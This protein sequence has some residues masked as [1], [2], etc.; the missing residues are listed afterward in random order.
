MLDIPIH[1]KSASL[2]SSRRLLLFTMHEKERAVAPALQQHW[3]IQCVVPTGINTD[4]YGTFS[5]EIARVGSQEHAAEAKLAAASQQFPEEDFLLVSE[6]AFYPHPDSPFITVNTELLLL[7][8]KRHDLRIR[9]WHTSLD[10]RART[11]VLQREDE[12]ASTLEAFSFPDFG[13]VL[14]RMD[15]EV[16][17]ESKKDFSDPE[18]L[19]RCFRT[20][21]QQFPQHLIRLSHDLR[22]H[23]NPL[24]M[25]HIEQT[26]KELMQH[27]NRI[28]PNCDLPGFTPVAAIRGLRC[29]VCAMPTRVTRAIQFRCSSCSH[30]TEQPPEHAPAAADPMYCDR[31]NP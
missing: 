5:G 2:F 7:W 15:Q 11:Q 25:A 28:C 18:E 8:D 23:R 21:K 30:E 29:A 3:G 26:A 27:M 16:L 17:I 14:S 13:V 24:R 22:A 31:C 20:W 4:L 6:G 10:T 12:I 19:K 9:A 1:P